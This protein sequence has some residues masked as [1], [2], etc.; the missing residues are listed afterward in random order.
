M[1]KILEPNADNGISFWSIFLKSVRSKS[2]QRAGRIIGFHFSGIKI[3]SLQLLSN[4]RIVSIDSKYIR[5]WNSLSKTSSLFLDMDP[6]HLLLNMKVYDKDGRNLGYISKVEQSGY[7]NDFDF[8]LYK[9]K[10]Y[11]PSKK[12]Y[13]DQIET[14]NKNIILKVNL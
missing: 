7:Y 10:F 6:I 9:K 1:A 14:L 11:L 8:L 2:G 3:V 4:G 12:I 13:S 5:N